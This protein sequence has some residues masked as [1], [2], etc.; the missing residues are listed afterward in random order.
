MSSGVEPWE[1]AVCGGALWEPVPV[2]GGI[3]LR[4]RPENLSGTAPDGHGWCAQCAYW[5]PLGANAP[6]PPAHR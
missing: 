5:R 3:D 1:C 6:R 2:N 4:D